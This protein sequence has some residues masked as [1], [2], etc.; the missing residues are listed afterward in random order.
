MNPPS[1][2]RWNSGVTGSTDTR[3]PFPAN[4]CSQLTCRDPL[5]SP[6]QLMPVQVPQD[7]LEAL[8]SGR[9]INAD[10]LAA[11]KIGTGL[12]NHSWKLTIPSLSP[13]FLQRINSIVFSDPIAVQENYIYLWNY[14]DSKGSAYRMPEP[15]RFGP[16]QL[17]FK[18]GDG[19]Y[20]R[21][22]AFVSG[23]CSRPT[24]T[25]PEM[26]KDAALAFA[27]FTAFF[28]P[29]DSRRLH[30]V[31]PSF[32]DLSARFN[33]FKAS[34]ANPAPGREKNTASMC[35]E[36]LQREK[37]AVLQRYFQQSG[38]FPLRIM[39]HDAKFSNVLLDAATDLVAAVVDYDTVMPGF[40]YSDLGDLV[41]SM[42]CQEDENHNGVPVIRKDFY[43]AI[44]NGYTE[45]L[46]GVLTADEL[47]W[48]H[49]PGL[50]MTYMQALR[51]LTDHL[52]GDIYY[53]VEY[54]GQNLD[55]ARN[56]FALLT[57]LERFLREAYGFVI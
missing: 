57:G 33:G 38:L 48:K 37:Y 30:T 29:L 5:I 42:T 25:S 15:L 16:D 53:Q 56:Q 3:F 46:S 20:W 44:I 49:A 8:L 22:F 45:G 43:K 11:E 21:A 6:D 10:N 40:F 28:S 1:C 17:L 31:L 2:S 27:S 32:H 9:N 26:A 52:N 50:L 47:K 35:R 39:H 41:R 19:A 51:F 34:L 4:D 18:S 24:A 55:R 7:V 12:I 36:L 14:R 54:P 23:T 13:I